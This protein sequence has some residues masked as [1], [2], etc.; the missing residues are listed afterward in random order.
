MKTALIA[1]TA[2]A[3]LSGAAQA[4]QT[5]PTAAVEFAPAALSSAEGR[6]AIRAR[7]AEAA[8][9]VCEVPRGQA[10]ELRDE[11]KA[12]IAAAIEQGEAQIQRKI[13]ALETR[14]LAQTDHASAGEG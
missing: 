1:F 7:I 3:A 9:E 6:D 11:R 8:D 4:D 5:P 2:L 13:A 12:C 14:R 10:L